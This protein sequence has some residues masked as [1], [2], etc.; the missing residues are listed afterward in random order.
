MKTR[1]KVVLCALGVGVGVLGAEQ[2]DPRVCATEV[3]GVGYVAYGIMRNAVSAG[4]SRVGTSAED[5]IACFKAAT[6][7]GMNTAY[8]DLGNLYQE[9]KQY[10]KAL[11]AYQKSA[12]KG[13]GDAM[14]QLG[15]ICV[16]GLGLPKTTTEHL[17]T[18]KKLR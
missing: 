7:A 12:D 15:I 3:P 14:V 17:N 6:Q 1:I 9:T 10:K 16:D 2:F 5:A 18:L 4:L 11:E 8:M 13:D